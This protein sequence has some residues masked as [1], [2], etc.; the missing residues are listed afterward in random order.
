MQTFLLPVKSHKKFVKIFSFS[1]F[2]YLCLEKST[3]IIDMKSKKY[4]LRQG[5]SNRRN[6]MLYE[7][8]DIFSKELNE[9]IKGLENIPVDEIQYYVG[10]YSKAINRLKSDGVK[11]LA[12][13][14]RFRLD[15]P[16]QV[17]S[18]IIHSWKELVMEQK[19]TIISDWEDFCLTRMLPCKYE[20]KLGFDK[21]MRNAIIEY[22]DL[23]K[24]RVE[25]KR[26]KDI[27]PKSAYL[28]AE[29][30]YYAYKER[31]SDKDITN[32]LPQTNEHF[33]KI[34]TDTIR[35]MLSGELLADN[36]RLRPEIIR[37]A[38]KIKANSCFKNIKVLEEL[39]RS[40]KPSF[41]PELGFDTTKIAS[42][43]YIVPKGQ[44]KLYDAVSA[45][46]ID[47]LTKAVLPADVEELYSRIAENPKTKEAGVF[48]DQI[49]KNVLA[50]TDIVD[51][52]DDATVQ[53]R[54]EF[55]T[56][57]KQRYS[58]IIYSAKKEITT[59]QVI[60]IYIDIYHSRPAAGPATNKEYGICCQSKRIWYYGKPRI[61]VEKAIENY[62]LKHKTFYLSELF[63][64]LKE[65]GYTILKSVRAPI[66][67][68]C[69]VDNKDTNHFCHKD[70]TS[71]F[72]QYSWRNSSIY[73]QSNWLLCRV[74][75][76]LLEEKAVEYETIVQEIIS[77]AKGTP[78]ENIMKK[79]VK[80]ILQKYTGERMP[81]SL[82]KG[83]IMANEPFFS[84]TD[85][86]T[87]GLRH[88]ENKG[89]KK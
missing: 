14:I 17:T 2:Y 66:T 25:N 79:R 68:Y 84:Q 59:E 87:I 46:I 43:Y 28:R 9:E 19:D 70:F 32:Y 76:I 11:S 49:I 88:I 13:L 48:N 27:V 20:E 52:L 40:K 39:S 81:L 44:K 16:L 41:I 74:K 8:T 57:D 30:L 65:N 36:A 38:E 29:I 45:G 7:P 82:K 21:N 5:K 26:F 64:H 31:F 54:A 47:T 24:E 83:K 80:T 86:N 15:N 18:K 34:R 22:A 58:R 12:D 73:G 53:I 1:V 10:N 50:D 60:K 42:S 33:R 69:S 4:D 72:P 35:Q 51:I 61:Q 85:F 23:L 77:R 37:H 71:D 55:L 75:E 62:A 3:F 56:S 67:K 6:T 89:W 63:A 78:Y